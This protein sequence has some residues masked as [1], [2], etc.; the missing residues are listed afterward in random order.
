[1]ST[2]TPQSF[3]PRGSQSLLSGTFSSLWAHTHLGSSLED[4]MAHDAFPG[5]WGRH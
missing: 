3:M 1:M 4:W 2:P 5:M